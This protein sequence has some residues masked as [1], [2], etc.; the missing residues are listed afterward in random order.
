MKLYSLIFT[1]L[2]SAQFTLAKM[3]WE[4]EVEKITRKMDSIQSNA[5]KLTLLTKWVTDDFLKTRPDSIL[6]PS[7]ALEFGEY[8][9]VLLDLIEAVKTPKLLSPGGEVTNRFDCEYFLLHWQL[10]LQPQGEILINKPLKTLAPLI[11]K[12]CQ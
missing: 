2:V 5:E 8:E 7:L 9:L 3:P 6:S 1:I 10:G 11:K 12:F 4:I